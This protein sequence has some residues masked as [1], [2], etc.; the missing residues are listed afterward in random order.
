M[1]RRSFLGRV[2]ALAGTVLVSGKAAARMLSSDLQSAGASD[3]EIA[4][5]TFAMAARRGLQEDPV[6]DIMAVIGSSFTGAPYEAHTI[7]VP[8]PER[9]V[10][11]LR[12]FD[13]TTF[14]ES[15]LA[16][17]R[18]VKLGTATYEAFQQ[19]LQLIRYRSGVIQGY[20]SR[21]HYF[22][23]W[24]ADNEKKK[25]VRDITHDLEGVAV[26]KP[27]DFMTTHRESYRQLADEDNVQAVAEAEHRLSER[28]YTVLTK[29]HIAAVQDRLQN[30]D[31]IALATSIKGLDVTHTGMAVRSGTVV[32][33]LHA[34]LSG[35]AVQLSERPLPEYVAALGARTTGI[36]V[37]RPLNP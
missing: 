22:I 10:C 32:K 23:D 3:Q 31:I 14:V 28:T 5:R 27:I 7:E 2:A 6:G 15:T 17:S 16:L 35:G 26:T 18:C 36:I 19:Q 33:F 25:I 11:D 37:S 30:G 13:C 20:P 4:L 12:T 34:P 1:M 29:G 9:L 8:G 24:I 21:L